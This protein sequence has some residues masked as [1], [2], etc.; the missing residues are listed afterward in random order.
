[1][2]DII[3]FYRQIRNIDKGIDTLSKRRKRRTKNI[4]SSFI[5]IL[6]EKYKEYPFSIGDKAVLVDFA[7]NLAFTVQIESIKG[8]DVR[9]RETRYCYHR[10]S[11]EPEI[12]GYETAIFVLPEKFYNEIKDSFKLDFKENDL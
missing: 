4:A 9:A 3:Y 12:E 10:F 11:I 2:N 8:K 1:M 6:A 5:P 7:E